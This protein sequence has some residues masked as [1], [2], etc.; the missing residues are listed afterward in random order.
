M[1]TAR[2]AP[3]LAHGIGGRQDQPL[4]FW[5]AVAGAATAV[6]VSFVGLGLL[7]TRP[8]L[9]T[10]GRPLPGLQ[11]VVDRAA[12]RLVVVTLL[13]VYLLLCLT[14]RDN[15][16]NPMPWLVY[17]YFWVG[18]VPLSVLFG[19]VWRRLNPLRLVQAA[20][21]RLARLDPAEG[22]YPLPRSIGYWPA[23]VGL[24]CFTW[25]EL[26]YP[27]NSELSTFRWVIGVYAA[28][29]L[30]AALLFGSGWF[31]RADA[32]EAWSGLFGTFSPLGRRPSRSVDGAVVPGGSRPEAGPDSP[33][34]D[35]NGDQDGGE[36]VLRSPLAGP[37]LL[38][39]APGLVA[40]VMVMLG[41]TAYDGLSGSPSW[42]GFVQGS[43]LP[44]Y[45]LPTL[46]LLGTILLLAA[47]Y[48]ACTAAAG[49]LAGVTRG[50]HG[51]SM[52]AAFAHSVIPVALGYVVAHYYT[53][54]ALEG[55]RGLAHLAD[56]RGSGR[57]LA[58][59]VH[60]GPV[61]PNLVAT[62][63]VLAVVTGHVLGVVLAHDRAVRL[64]PRRVAVLGQVPLLVLMVGLTC[65]GLI[66]LFAA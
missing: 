43:S 2:L 34:A 45:L 53:L 39:P 52:P 54:L 16:D 56:P 13:L 50:E 26:V 40:V 8:R 44:V 23:A 62:V 59:S 46:G 6:V 61:D 49:R 4:P 51:E 1:T 14:G 55:Q 65:T 42:A 35:E 64:F 25:L 15:A 17:V 60:P 21:T 41:S 48:L 7:W 19:R 10:A 38:R 29:H 36:L 28:V 66:L 31:D 24:V 33:I 11:K 12:P 27:D 47:L 22:L 32:F 9:R 30:F 18:L 5:W 58:V 63:Q 3:L 20:L 37:D 57:L